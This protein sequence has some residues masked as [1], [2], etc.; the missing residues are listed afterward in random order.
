MKNIYIK[1]ITEL[2]TV[3]PARIMAGSFIQYKENGFVNTKVGH[4]VGGILHSYKD[5]VNNGD[6]E[7]IN[8]AKGHNCWDE[9]SDEWDKW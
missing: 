2:T 7:Y 9:E 6:D 8:L 4:Y 5:E 3:E 1:P